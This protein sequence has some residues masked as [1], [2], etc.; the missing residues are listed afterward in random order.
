MRTFPAHVI[1]ILLA[2]VGPAVAAEK[3]PQPE[4]LE[5][6]QAAVRAVLVEN[7]LPA[8]GIAM[9]DADGEVWVDALGKANLEQDIDADADSMFRI[10]STTK[11]L[12]SLAVL[13]LVEEGR[14]S[15]DDKLADLAPDIEFENPWE[16]SD[17][18]RVVHLL[19]HTTGWDDLHLPEFAHNDPR[20]ASLKEGLDFHPHSRVSRWKPGSRMSYCNSGPAVAAYV[21]EKV[22]G[23][24]FEDFVQESFFDPMGME[25]MTFL[26]SD[27]YKSKG[28]TLYANGNQPQDYWHLST[29]PSGSINASPKDMAKLVGFF[30]HR[31]AVNGQQ[32]LTT[33]S[34]DRMETPRS[35]AGAQAGIETG[36][37]LSNYASSHKSWIFR[38]HSGGVIGGRTE[39]AYLPEADVGHVI[40]A[41][42]DDYG[43]FAEIVQLV[44][45]FETRN[46]DAAPPI[47]A[48]AT[49]KPDIGGLYFII[50]PRNQVAYFLERVLGLQKIWFEEQRLKRRGFFGGNTWNYVPASAGLFRAENTGAIAVAPV[51]DPLAGPVVHVD[52]LVLKEIP[53]W[54]AYGQLGIVVLWGISIATSVLFLPVWGIRKLRGKVPAG[55]ATRIRVWPLLAGL[56]I[57]VAIGLFTMGY[58]DPFKHLAAPTFYSVG[59]MLASIAFAVFAF[60]GVRMSV[61]ARHTPMNRWTYWHS[62]IASGVHFVVAAY[63]LWF[64][65]IGMMTWA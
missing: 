16:E 36:Y 35:T 23:Q 11:M 33:A 54:L 10:G 18:V 2:L 14:L 17:P 50:N 25:A 56:S 4:T 1:V 22:T 61:L 28:V 53:A 65:A 6:L 20:P 40:M 48:E 59:I 8:V 64:G 41:N 37:A 12:V 42:S 60:L 21:I 45:N 31:G 24:V 52:T 39:L 47:V 44:R 58:S 15:L 62:A 38:E 5:E 26:M 32:L 27:T 63:L 19:E 49:E 9:V 30:I 57:L 29:R 55:P 3:A 34:I 13:K 51:E 7:D 43:A 46:L